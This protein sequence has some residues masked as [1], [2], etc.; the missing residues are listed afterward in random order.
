MIEPKTARHDTEKRVGRVLMC[1][2]TSYDLLYEI[3][4][5]MH[6]TNKPDK[7]LARQQWDELHTTLRDVVG[8]DVELVP[9]A[10]D[11]PDMVFTANAGLVVGNRAILA[12]FRHPQRQLEEPH[13]NLWFV[14]NGFSV[15]SL[16]DDAAFEGEGDALF[17]GETLVAGYLKRS[18][19]ASHRRIGELL[20]CRVLSLELVDDR[21][22]HLDTCFLPLGGNSVAYYPGAFDAYAQQVIREHFDAVPVNHDEALLFACNSVVIGKNVV[23]PAGCAN[24]AWRLRDEGFEV[25][26][27]PMSEFI[28]SGGACKCLTLYLPDRV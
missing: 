4:A 24:I 19:I 27:I 14:R 5:W 12:R 2:P 25:F 8:V 18:D 6:V 11:C 23:M 26:P 10:S 3:N 1:E 9:Q 21:W 7:R 15:D 22:Y 16:G 28:K 13:F 20:G 17:V